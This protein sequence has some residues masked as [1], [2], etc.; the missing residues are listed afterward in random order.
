MDDE[1]YAR[2]AY[3]ETETMERNPPQFIAGWFVTTPFLNFAISA[4]NW[5]TTRGW[6][7]IN[8]KAFMMLV[9]TPY[10]LNLDFLQSNN[11]Y[12]QIDQ[13]ILCVRIKSDYLKK[14]IDFF[15]SK[16]RV[17]YDVIEMKIV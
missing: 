6:Q 14:D 13:G 3:I 7:V 8:P 12:N 10:F 16:E 11:N 5:Q 15:Q 2:V 4:E 9:S 1:E 17:P